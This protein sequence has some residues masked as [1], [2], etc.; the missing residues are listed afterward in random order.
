MRPRSPVDRLIL[1][2]DVPTVAEARAVVAETEGDVGVYKVGLELI[3]AGGVEFAR[4]LAASGK[5]VFLDAKLHDIDNT[6]AG[7]VRSILDI[8]ATYLTLHAYPKTMAAAVATR[9]GAPLALLAVTVLT[10]FDDADLAAAG[11]RGSVAETVAM[12]AAQAKAAGVDG[13]VCS[14]REVGALRALVGPD[15]LLVTPGVRPAGTAAGDQKR[16]ATPAEAIRSGADVI[17]VGRP[18]LAA[19]DR[20]AAARAIVAEIAAT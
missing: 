16:V 1:A 3:Y 6:V 10:A 17:V 4:E 7:A 2:L 20:R 13:I 15:V 19:P 8:G 9:G 14:P 11:Y 5:R 12:R 18:V